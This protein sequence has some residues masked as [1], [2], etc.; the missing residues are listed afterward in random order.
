MLWKTK[1]KHSKVG[2]HKKVE[3]YL[4]ILKIFI[5]HSIL[6]IRSTQ[7][8]QETTTKSQDPT[9]ALY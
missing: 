1:F 4:Y 2:K 8:L 9:N 3:G 6:W 7:Q 5:L